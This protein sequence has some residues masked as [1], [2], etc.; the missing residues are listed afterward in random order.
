MNVILTIENKE[1]IP[2]RALAYV[3]NWV[4]DPDEI[5]HACATPPT[6]KVGSTSIRNRR[7]LPAYLVS[8]SAFRSMLSV[9]WEP[10]IVALGCLEK[11]LKADERVD[12]ENWERCRKQAVLQL[13]DGA[14]VWLDEFQRWFSNTRPLK[15]TATLS[16]NGVDDSFENESDALNLDPVIP[17]EF[18][19]A[20]FSG[21]ER[22]LVADREAAVEDA[23]EGGIDGK[24]A[25][26]VTAKPK[27]GRPKTI[28]GKVCIL[29]QLIDHM[30]KGKEIEPGNLPGTAA[31]LLDACQ[32]IEKSK[33]GKKSTFGTSEDTFKTWLKHSGYGFKGGRAPKDEAHFWTQL[34][35][36]TMGLMD[37]NIFTEV[38]DKT[39][40]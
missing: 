26:V 1:A 11:R 30:A 33:T 39:A 38:I 22:Y 29:R 7:A 10:F 17:P 2:V 24:Q 36:E 21:L 20:I 13:P 4:A 3:S 31:D 23:T 6:K 12:G 14:F 34:C 9:E 27:S 40:P 18:R 19:E 5:V 35:V 15:E 37:E 8:G 25:T 16:N 32:R 28:P